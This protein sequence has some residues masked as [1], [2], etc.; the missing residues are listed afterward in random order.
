MIQATVELKK[1]LRLRAQGALL[2]D[3]RTPAEFSEATIPGAV[4]VPIFSNEERAEI[5]TLYKQQGKGVARKRGIEVVSPKIPQLMEQ[6]EVLR[7]GCNGPVVVFCWR[8]G[9]RSLAMTSLMNLAGIHARQLIGGYKAFRS[10]IC[11]YFEEADWQPIY[12]LRGLTGVGKTQVLHH[13]AEQGYPVVDLEGLANHRGSAFGALGLPQQPGQKMFEAL[14]WDRLLQ[15][16]DAAY[17]LTEGES[18]HIGRL[19]V[20]KRF[21]QA[22][23]VQT[24]LWLG[25]SLDF[26]TKIILQDYPALDQLREQFE[27]PICAL[28]ERLGKKI[29]NQLLGLL[30]E[31]RWEELV[32]ELMVHY[33][34]PLYLHTKPEQR[35]EIELESVDAGVE[36]VAA[37]LQELTS[38]PES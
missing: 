3:V 9:M 18:L 37:A 34:D 1:V 19:L 14:L 30:N 36:R 29:V 26:R 24:S 2:V 8:G 23:Q 38:S 22:M 6:V 28:K 35:V 20:P 15:L 27:K 32:Y 4:N 10:H 12:V 11:A 13:L 25:A 21:H 17:L 33:Y 5:G 31:G 16:R 7:R